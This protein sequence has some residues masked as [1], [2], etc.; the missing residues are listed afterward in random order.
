MY[1][2]IGGRSQG[3]L[4]F[5]KNLIKNAKVLNCEKE[6]I[7]F[8]IDFDIVF[9][10]HIFIRKL[11]EKDIEPEAWFEQRLKFFENK[12]LIGDEVGSGIVPVEAFERK[13]R[14]EVGKTYVFLAKNSQKVYR[15]W[16]GIGSVLM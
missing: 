15:V 11:L 5:A 6:D 16:A 1:L 7:N 4:D 13:W 9:N 8:G 3:K 10:I 2:I 12:I 14:D